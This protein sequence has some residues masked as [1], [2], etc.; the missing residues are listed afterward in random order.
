MCVEGG[1]SEGVLVEWICDLY[2]FAGVNGERMGM[3][4]GRGCDWGVWL[5][6]VGDSGCEWLGR[7]RDGDRRGVL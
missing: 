1:F 2:W 4:C 7:D 3:I 6:W 5:E